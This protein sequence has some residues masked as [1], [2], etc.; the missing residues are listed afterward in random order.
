MRE[1]DG[2]FMSKWMPDITQHA[3]AED[4]REGRQVSPSHLEVSRERLSEGHRF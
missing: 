1:N 3:R 2:V 4:W